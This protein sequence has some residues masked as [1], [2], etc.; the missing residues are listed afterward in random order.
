MRLGFAGD[1]PCL[2]GVS[3]HASVKDATT[4]RERLDSFNPVSIHASVKD[5]TWPFVVP[6]LIMW[7]FNPRICKR[8]DSMFVK[9][10][11]DDTF[12]L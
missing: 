11:I 1:C 4:Y 5:A 3:I 12:K 10:F 9:S 6:V 8:C 7:S 2:V